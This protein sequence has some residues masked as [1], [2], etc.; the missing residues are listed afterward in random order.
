MNRKHM[1][2]NYYFRFYQCGLTLEMTAE[3]CFKSVRTVKLWDSGKSIPPECKRLMRL[4]TKS[5][6]GIEW[7]GFSMQANKLVLPTGERLDPQQVVT[8]AA[9]LELAPQTEMEIMQKLG[10]YLRALDRIKSRKR[11]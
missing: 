8:A 9:I 7:D 2:E 6:L 4:Y 1:T 10:R 3:L 5:E 11:S